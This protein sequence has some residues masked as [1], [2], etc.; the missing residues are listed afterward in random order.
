MNRAFAT[1]APKVA[2][3]VPGCPQPM[4]LDYIR[5]AAI[6][7]CERTLM[8]RYTQPVF[9]L[10]P[11]VHE[12]VYNKP[13]NTDVHV[14]FD[15]MMNDRP[16][17]K[18]TLEQALYTHP[19]WADLYSGEDPS[20]AWSMT[21][22]G[23][24]NTSAFNGAEFNA[25]PAYVVPE[26]IVAKAS[27]PRS[28]TQLTPDRF[29]ILPLPDDAETYKLRMF[30]ALKPSR[31][32]TGMSRVVF[33]ELED[34]ILHDALQHLLVMPGVEWSDRE[35][36][37]YHA[38]QGLKEHTARRARANLGNVRGGLAASAPRFA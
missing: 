30:Y 22:S 19:E 7:A 24:V 23:A 10:L 12:Y 21:P 37:T 15:A 11:G 32:A 33:D 36:A 16:L 35:L 6:R 4:I 3:S 8:W 38:R 9:D 29:I 26:A 1:L 31:D 28:V 13:D 27:Q 14:L 20:V 2:T 18:L 34:T 5:D 17:R 25:N